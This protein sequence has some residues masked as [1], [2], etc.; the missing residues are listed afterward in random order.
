M[1]FMSMDM[2]SFITLEMIAYTTPKNE[3]KKLTLDQRRSGFAL[4]EVAIIYARKL[5]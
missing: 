2:K 4:T 1:S 3:N 5:V